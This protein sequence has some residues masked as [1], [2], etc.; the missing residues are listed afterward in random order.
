MRIVVA[1]IALVLALAN[2][3]SAQSTWPSKP[4]RVIVAAAPG[5]NPDILGRLLSQKLTDALGKPFVVENV[6]GAGGMVAAKLVAGLP[7]DGHAVMLGDSGA[8]AINVALTPDLGYKPLTDFTPVTALVT[9]PT[10][11]VLHPSVEAK[12][13]AEFVALAKSKPGGIS[14]GSAGQGSVHHL[15]MAVF[16]ARAGIDVLHAPY[17]GGTALVGALMKGEVQAGWSGIPNVKSLIEGGQLR[18]L[19]ISTAQR[20]KSMPNVPTCIEQGFPNFDIATMIGLQLPAKAPQD[21]VARLQQAVAKA[22]RESDMTERFLAL[23]M[24][25]RENGTADYAKFMKDDIDRYS[26][27]VKDAGGRFN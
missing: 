14:Y 26:A 18:V 25:F 21:V 15:T 6:P 5:G 7:A 23:G 12:T 2:Q 27:A 10:V 24:E 19:C 16:A 9:V 8:L 22:L 13:L 1:A 4:V 17:R 20:S 3:A 11:L